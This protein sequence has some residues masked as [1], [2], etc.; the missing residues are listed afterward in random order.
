MFAWNS[1]LRFKVKCNTFQ[2][3]SWLVFVMS[4]LWK[5]TCFSSVQFKMI[6]R[7]L[8]KPTVHSTTS[9]KFLEC[10]LSNIL[11]CCSV[12]NIGPFSSFQERSFNTFCF[13]TAV[14]QATVGVLKSLALCIDPTDIKSY[15]NLTVSSSH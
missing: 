11:W 1:S 7:S 9:Q 6:S 4:R 13:N 15:F 8:G 10:C 14:L 2:A 3:E 12:F 5:R